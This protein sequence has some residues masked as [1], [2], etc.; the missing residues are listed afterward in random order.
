M[1]DRASQKRIRWIKFLSYARVFDFEEMLSR[2]EHTKKSDNSV[3]RLSKVNVP[4]FPLSKGHE[5][6]SSPNA[7]FQR[8]MLH[9]AKV[10]RIRLHKV[11][12]VGCNV[13]SFYPSKI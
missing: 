3:T 8:L 10:I 9:C 6:H 1:L 5:S 2:V 4:T 11:D 12:V 7:N 13:R